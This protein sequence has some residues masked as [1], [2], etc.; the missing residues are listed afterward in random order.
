M[1]EHAQ[2][3][4]QRLLT[5]SGHKLI[6]MPLTQTC[7]DDGCTVVG[8]DDC[9]DDIDEEDLYNCSDFATQEEAQQYYEQVLSESGYDVHDLD[10]NSNC[11]ACEA[12]P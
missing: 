1:L 7:T 3:G 11:E 8:C 5:G 2:M 9:D 12:L 4:V 10:R 6:N